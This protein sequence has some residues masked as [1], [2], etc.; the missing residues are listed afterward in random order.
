VFDEVTKRES[1]KNAAR[2]A[3]FVFGSTAFQ[4]GVVAAAII[5]GQ[6][7]R[8]AVEE[9]A[10]DVKFVRQAAPRPPPPPPAPPP[11]PRKADAKPRPPDAPKLAP[12]PPPTALIQ[13]KDVQEEMKVNPNEPKEPEYDYGSS[14]SAGEGV[15]GGVVG[16]AAP[17]NEV[18]EAPAYATSG[19]KKPA[20]VEKGCVGRSVRTPRE[21]Q[22]L[23]STVTVKF[24]IG[25]DGKPS[26]FEAISDVPDKRI[27]DAIWQ[28]IQ[29]CQFTPGIDPRGQPQKIW[30]IL[31]IRFSTG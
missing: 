3:G 24:A 15:V 29:S 20:E 12:P 9:K 21:L 6:Q 10:V 28:A 4:V 11:P 23:V 14:A 5:A 1:G 13:P 19:F 16:G 30:M 25:R 27:A 31:P 8:A 17:S 26:L 18:E 22:G 2:R 7:I